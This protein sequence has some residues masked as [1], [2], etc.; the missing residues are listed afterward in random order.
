[1]GPHQSWNQAL[2]EV[3]VGSLLEDSIPLPLPPAAFR[4]RVP[5]PCSLG[6]HCNE[7]ASDGGKESLGYIWPGRP[8]SIRVL[9]M[10]K[11][12]LS[13]ATQKFFFL[14]HHLI[15]ITQLPWGNDL[16]EKHDRSCCHDYCWVPWS[17]GFDRTRDWHEVVL[18]QELIHY[19]V[20]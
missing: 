15:L 4:S 17:L 8:I 2:C 12:A 16:P 10:K 1:M 19:R 3:S 13:P 6:V 7:T 14:S 11:A 20:N 5:G 9:A 18:M